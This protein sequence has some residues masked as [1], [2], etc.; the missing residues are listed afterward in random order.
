MEDYTYIFTKSNHPWSQFA[1]ILPG[2]GLRLYG[3]QIQSVQQ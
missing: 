2:A 3:T 1:G